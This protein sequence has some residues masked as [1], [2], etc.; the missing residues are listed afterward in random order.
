MTLFL[1]DFLL[2]WRYLYQTIT[3]VTLFVS[4]HLLERRYWYK[5]IYTTMTLF[6]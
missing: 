6:I 5:T 1:A 3:N 2:Q 4:A